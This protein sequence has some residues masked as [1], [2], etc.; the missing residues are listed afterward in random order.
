MLALQHPAR[1]QVKSMPLVH[2]TEVSKDT[3]KR[4]KVRQAKS[5]ADAQRRE[6]TWTESFAQPL[7]NTWHFCKCSQSRSLLKREFTF[8]R[9][10]NFWVLAHHHHHHHHPPPVSITLLQSTT[11][12][13]PPPPYPGP[14]PF[15]KHHHPPP[16]PHPFPFPST[17][18]PPPRVGPQP[19]L[20]QP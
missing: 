1:A 19:T 17:T 18:T 10:G 7:E 12:T 5:N 6:E 20:N 15:P 4:M 16:P 9:R 13:T 3:T 2:C 8:F 11:T 14:F